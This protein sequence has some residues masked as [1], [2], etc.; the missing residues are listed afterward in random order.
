MVTIFLVKESNEDIRC[1]ALSRRE[2]ERCKLI[3]E[4]FGAVL[5]IQE[6]TIGYDDTFINE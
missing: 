6:V 2:A 1:I 3:M 4:K 5:H